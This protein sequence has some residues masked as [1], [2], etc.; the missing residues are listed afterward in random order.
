MSACFDLIPQYCSCAGVNFFSF[1]FGF[2][3]IVVA[4]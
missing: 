1:E 4:S 3:R 2:A